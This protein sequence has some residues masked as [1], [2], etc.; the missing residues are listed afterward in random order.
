MRSAEWVIAG[1]NKKILVNLDQLQAVTE[2]DEAKTAI[3]IGNEEFHIAS[4][5]MDVLRSIPKD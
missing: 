4:S 5:Y 1:H 3:F 2:I